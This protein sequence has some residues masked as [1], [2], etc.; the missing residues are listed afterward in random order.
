MLEVKLQE[1]LEE[2]LEEKLIVFDFDGTLV[3]SRKLIVE[4][5][6]IVFT[7]FRLPVPSPE[8]SIA[9]IGKSLELV[10]AELAG[11]GAP[12]ADMVGAY[13][14]LLPKLRADPAFA[15]TPFGGIAEL[16]SELSSTDATVL[17]IAT[18][19]TSTAILPAL[20]TLGWRGYFHTLQT[21]D[22]APSKP[23][24]AMLLQALEETGAKAPDSIFIGDT[25][26]DMEMAR[27]AGF[28]AIGVDWGYHGAERLRSAGANQVAHEVAELRTYIQD[29]RWAEKGRNR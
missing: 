21:A 13:G 23:H 26:F 29:S 10:L 27:A 5:H 24:P 9:L 3:D 20:D 2:K 16:L 7:E 25:T 1:K 28:H 4:S 22:M 18:G 14:R 8:R 6:R 19:H 11:D 17:G 15:E 12:I